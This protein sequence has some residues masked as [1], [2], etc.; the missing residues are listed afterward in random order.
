MH[1]CIGKALAEEGLETEL[2]PCPAQKGK[3]I[4]GDCFQEPVGWDLMNAVTSK[5]IAGAAMKRSQKGLLL[6]G[7]IEIE[8]KLNINENKFENNF[9]H[10]LSQVLE[11]PNEYVEW[12]EDFA[13]ER[14]KICN[15][16]SDLKWKK[17]RVRT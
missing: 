3:V 10:F 15:Q 11:E 12:P 6:Q 13:D 17:N 4:P 5:K 9:I 2:Q 8:Q 16:F 1:Q 14:G 7:T